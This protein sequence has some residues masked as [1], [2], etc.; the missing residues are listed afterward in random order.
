MVSVQ[1]MKR[2]ALFYHSI[3]GRDSNRE[4]EFVLKRVAG[5]LRLSVI[6]GI[7]HGAQISEEQ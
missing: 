4:C 5:S 6:C 1:F 3:L 7:P 2:L